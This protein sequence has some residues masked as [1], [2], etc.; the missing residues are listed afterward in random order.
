LRQVSE[1][2]VKVDALQDQG[3][4][5]AVKDWMKRKRRYRN[6]CA[7]VARH[8]PMAEKRFNRK[9]EDKSCHDTKSV[10]MRLWL[11]E[12]EG[13]KS[14]I[15]IDDSKREREAIQL[16]YERNAVVALAPPHDWRDHHKH[17][18]FA[19]VNNARITPDLFR[20]RVTKAMVGAVSDDPHAQTMLWEIALLQADD[21]FLSDEQLGGSSCFDS[22]VSA[23]R[24]LPKEA[25]SHNDLITAKWALAKSQFLGAS[26]PHQYVNEVLMA[27]LKLKA[28]PKGKS[29]FWFSGPSSEKRE[30]IESLKKKISAA[31][32]QLDQ[33]AD[34]HDAQRLIIKYNACLKCA[35]SFSVSTDVY[36]IEPH[37]R[38]TTSPWNLR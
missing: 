22:C 5:P 29:F 17:P 28:A 15:F 13:S 35:K 21:P 36:T 3:L 14:V 26:K 7:D 9:D 18:S 27:L 11:T 6:I 25:L 37:G 20:N 8:D 16:D 23:Q 24:S 4:R 12:A 10:A 19:S 32:E 34:H 30:Q 1:Q 33:L 31:K 2:Q 38:P